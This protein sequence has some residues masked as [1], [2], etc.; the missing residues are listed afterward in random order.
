MLFQLLKWLKK[1]KKKLQK[2]IEQQTISEI[3]GLENEE[4]LIEMQIRLQTFQ[5][6]LFSAKA[7][8]ASLL[9]LLPG[10]DFRLDEVQTNNLEKLTLD[11]EELEET[12]LVNRP[13]L[14]IQ[15]LEE[16]VNADEIRATMLSYFPNPSFFGTYNYDRN[17]FL[18]NKT[19]MNMGLRAA[20][21][22][23]SFPRYRQ[24]QKVAERK[25]SNLEK[26]RKSLSIGILTQVRLAYLTHKNSLRQYHLANDLYSV[27]NRLY[28]AVKKGEQLGEYG[29]SEIL[30]LQ[31]ESLFS[32]INSLTSYAEMHIS[33]ERINNAIGKP[34]FYSY[35]N[36][37]EIQNSRLGLKDEKQQKAI[38][39]KIA[40]QEEKE[41]E[42][43]R[44][45]LEEDAKEQSESV[46]EEAKEE[47]EELSNATEEAQEET[48]SKE[49]EEA[50]EQEEKQVQDAENEKMVTEEADEQ[51]EKGIRSGYTADEELLIDDEEN[52]SPSAD[53]ELN[54][55]D[56]KTIM[57]SREKKE[58]QEEEPRR[59]KKMIKLIVNEKRE[60][61]DKRV[62]MISN[63]IFKEMEEKK[64][65]QKED[66]ASV[67]EK[68]YI[69]LPF[70]PSLIKEP[71]YKEKIVDKLTKEQILELVGPDMADPILDDEMIASI[72]NK[73]PLEP[74]KD[75]EIA[76]LGEDFGDEKVDEELI[77]RIFEERAFRRELAQIQR[78]MLSEQDRLVAKIADQEP[79][80]EKQQITLFDR[81]QQ[82]LFKDEE[83]QEIAEEE[84]KHATE[85]EAKEQVSNAPEVEDYEEKSKAKT[86]LQD[87]EDLKA[88][89]S[90]DM[91][92]EVFELDML[93]KIDTN[94]QEAAQHS[95]ASEQK[96][97]SQ[98]LT[99]LRDILEE[100]H[101][102]KDLPQTLAAELN[103]EKDA[104]LAEERFENSLE[105]ERI[106]AVSKRI[107]DT[108]FKV[109]EN[110]EQEINPLSS[111]RNEERFEYGKIL[112]S[113]KQ[114]IH[115]RG[116]GR[117]ENQ[118]ETRILRKELEQT[119]VRIFG[120][121]EKTFEDLVAKIPSLPRLL[122]RGDQLFENRIREEKITT[123]IPVQSE[124]AESSFYD[125]SQFIPKVGEESIRP[126]LSKL[127]EDSFFDRSQFIP[128]AGEESIRPVLSKLAEDSFFERSQFDAKE[129]LTHI[130]PV[131]SELAESKFFERTEVEAKSADKRPVFSLVAE[132]L[133]RE[134]S[135]FLAK[136]PAQST[137]PTLSELAETQFNERV[138]IQKKAP[139]I[140]LIQSNTTSLSHEKGVTEAKDEGDNQSLRNIT[141]RQKSEKLFEERLEIRKS[142]L[143]NIKRALS[144][145][146][147]ERFEEVRLERIKEK[148]KIRSKLSE[149]SELKF[150]NRLREK[151][152][153]ES[154]KNVTRLGERSFE[155]RLLKDQN[156][157]NMQSI[158][159]KPSPISEAGFENKLNQPSKSQSEI[160]SLP[161][162]TSLMAEDSFETR[163]MALEAKA[164][165]SIKKLDS[166]LYKRSYSK[167]YENF[168]TRI[169]PQNREISRLFM[170]VLS[171]SDPQT[172]ERFE[173]AYKED[174]GKI[175]SA[176]TFILEE[177]KSKEVLKSKRLLQNKGLAEKI[178]EDRVREMKRQWK[179]GRGETLFERRSIQVNAREIADAN[180]FLKNL[181]ALFQSEKTSKVER[182]AFRSN[183]MALKR[184]EQRLIDKQAQSLNL[185]IGARNLE[186]FLH[187]KKERESLKKRLSQ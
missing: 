20:W 34:L 18:I 48:S 24:S 128:K 107:L 21:D 116:D 145:T 1:D 75:E 47:N 25:L 99:S 45:I 51:L 8:L 108:L 156:E 71:Y 186:Q 66:L 68:I 181:K 187:E 132:Q 6:D 177:E 144:E 160:I 53:E 44:R 92:D 127:A 88:A 42:K 28:D 17:H 133:F 26:A 119:K 62:D 86:S 87:A 176:S 5:N 84:Q 49:S 73:K 9:G 169:M 140:R 31:A 11:V 80:E 183:E 30:R 57:E 97:D 180:P 33:L 161:R 109:A 118:F 141:K 13:E 15:D 112:Q 115:V 38:N 56:L 50:K 137:R 3:E 184:F 162:K 23:L 113:E 151:T 46:E 54:E 78:S 122:S 131:L 83:Q 150:E 96:N 104:G 175:S 165:Q 166:N 106:R 32:K 93:A 102:D 158:H 67:F 126:V 114:E 40:A 173:N 147:E 55:E 22:L 2:Q 90:D 172:E 105:N 101:T 171:Q 4:R 129:E 72:L 146:A 154:V 69:K 98:E 81:L 77:T 63:R 16:K 174:D 65:E 135:F 74:S 157:E 111:N 178:F 163:F 142:S 70:V 35:I 167:A 130:E 124:L 134:R 94:A 170:P 91:A 89:L 29:G 85:N 76:S 100:D 14:F 27:K 82:I 153:I 64:Q 10:T 39:E 36:L 152:V 43:T 139:A 7:E 155:N 58:Q 110:L 148:L 168:E 138:E 159:S 41:E 59:I 120:L 19:W 121:G 12:A 37:E 79:Q 95:S 136:D 52:V 149:L 61:L 123:T 125:R 179:M 185:E 143:Q 117:G 60:A 182:T 164:S 103:T